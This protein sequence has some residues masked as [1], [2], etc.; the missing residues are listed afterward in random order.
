MT[1]HAPSVRREMDLSEAGDATCDVGILGFRA[2]VRGPTAPLH[3]FRS[4]RPSGPTWTSP[5]GKGAP[6]DIDI[7]PDD[8]HPDWHRIVRDGRT[9]HVVDTGSDVLAYVERTIVA[10][11]LEHLGDRYLLVHAG[12]VANGSRG[13]VLP[14]ASG[15]GKTT[16]VAGLLGSGCEY[17]SDE[18]AVLEP[19]TGRLLPFAKS[20]GVKVGSRRVLTPLYPALAT[21]ISGRMV[22]GQAVWYL[23][24]PPAAWPARPVPVRY[25]VLPRYVPRART[26]LVPIGRSAALVGL[27]QQSFN[28]RAHG[29]RGVGALTRMLQGAECY[30]LTV[31]DLELAVDSILRLLRRRME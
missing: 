6:S 26:T 3:E 16:L 1:G 21:E 4:V 29:A 20:L 2:R 30:A 13:L 28:V 19:G 15:S 17:F 5:T 25:V 9:A 12:A 23:P 10:G 24:P 8:P 11:A 22:D 14:A 18:V 31:G 7:I 27:L